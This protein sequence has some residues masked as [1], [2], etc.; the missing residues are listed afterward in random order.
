MLTA[1]GVVKFKCCLA[2][3]AGGMLIGFGFGVAVRWLLR[4]MRQRDAGRDQQICLTLAVAYLSFYVANSPAEV[5]GKHA[6]F[7]PQAEWLTRQDSCQIYCM[8]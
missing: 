3:C 1:F 6:V 8:L 2:L 5:S 7:L 4:W